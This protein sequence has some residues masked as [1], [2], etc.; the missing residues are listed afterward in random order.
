MGDKEDRVFGR[1]QAYRSLR[2]LTK[3]YSGKEKAKDIPAAGDLGGGSAS[4]YLW[5]LSGRRMVY[6]TDWKRKY[7]VLVGCQ[8]YYYDHNLSQGGDR[9]AGVID[10][11]CVSDCVEAPLTDHK[12]ATNVFILI[13]KERGIFEQGRYYLSAETLIDM[14]TWVAK[15]KTSLK[16]IN[17]NISAKKDGKREGNLKTV[18]VSDNRS[19]LTRKQIP[20]PIYASIKNESIH[21]SNSMSTLP[22]LCREEGDMAWLN[23]SMEVDPVYGLSGVDHNLT[24][25][26]SSSDD[27]LNE[28]FSISFSPKHPRSADTSL[29]R[30]ASVNKVKPE[31]TLQPAGPLYS[32][33]QHRQS[34]PVKPVD[35]A[36]YLQKMYADMDRIDRQLEMVAKVECEKEKA[37]IA[38]FDE[39]D[40]EDSDHS[41]VDSVKENKDSPQESDLKI[42]KI[43]DMMTDLNRQSEELQKMFRKISSER[44]STSPAKQSNTKQGEPITIT[45]SMLEPILSSLARYQATMGELETHARK[46]MSEIHSTHQRV[47][48]SLAESEAAKK[49]FLR[50]KSQAE[51]ILA[52]LQQEEGG[53]EDTHS[54]PQPPVYAQVRKG[55]QKQQ[56]P[57][58]NSVA[59]CEGDTI[60]G[61]R[62]YQLRPRSLM[63]SKTE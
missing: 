54:S 5:R 22:S 55:R 36:D 39:E 24:Y 14:K 37:A 62:E 32:K 19:P 57:T 34:S 3:F 27:S 61:R 20:E 11:R 12:K 21:R 40:Q 51:E 31:I 16:N 56:P 42:K 50:L 28:S 58:R 15:L 25:S 13:A 6:M 46:V 45:M 44:I 30:G 33:L 53:T 2:T 7:F 9:G 35:S 41:V 18:E 63:F 43:E 38:R 47:V 52:K 29:G 59:V 8:L 4:G 49:S 1:S 10:L 48:K 60:K 23:R 26:Y 17:S